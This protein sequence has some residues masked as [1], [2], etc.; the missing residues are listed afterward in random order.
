MTSERSGGVDAAHERRRQQTAELMSRAAQVEG[1]ARDALLDEAVTV[2]LGVARAVARRFRNRGI[3]LEDLEQIASLALVRAARRF[4]P[5]QGRDFLQYAVPTISGELKRH[6][7]DHGWVIRPTRRVQ[8]TQARIRA[9]EKQAD[10]AAPRST[11]EIAAALGISTDDVVEALAATHC[12]QPLS[13][14]AEL[15]TGGEDFSLGD[16]LSA[17]NDREVE[18][19]EA[20]LM[21]GP[22][23][24]DLTVRDRRILYLRFVEDL[25]QSEIG[26]RVGLSQMQIS[27]ILTRSL[28]QL[29]EALGAPA[30]VQA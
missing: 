9:L 26:Q 6:F 3:P 17:D 4:D 15:T 2:N 29:R 25:S 19:L 24:R 11:S 20:R 8:E 1:P 5:A 30:P 7:R 27:R 21:L 12:Y 22:A 16:L 14:E 23:L 18:A 28:A 13:L 10:D